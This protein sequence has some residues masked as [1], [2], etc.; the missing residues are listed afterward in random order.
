MHHCL[1]TPLETRLP[2]IRLAVQ[3]A[4]KR[5]FAGE[6]LAVARRSLK[7]VQRQSGHRLGEDSQTGKHSGNGRGIL[8]RDPHASRRP[9]AVFVP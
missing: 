8:G 9:P 6:P 1:L 2:V 5:Q 3:P 7:Q 4:I